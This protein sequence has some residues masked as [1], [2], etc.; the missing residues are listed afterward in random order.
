MPNTPRLSSVRAGP[1]SVCLGWG[2]SNRNLFSY[3]SGDW[4][5]KIKMSAG[6]LLSEATFLGLWMAASSLHPHRS[7]LCVSACVSA[8]L[9]SS[10]KDTSHTGLEFALMTSFYCNDFFKGY[11][12]K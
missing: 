2:L 7:S 10:C 1:A 3:S 8:L 11:I 5:S 12:P 4:N 6:L 9:C